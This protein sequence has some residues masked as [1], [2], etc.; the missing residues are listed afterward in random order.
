M[1]G[2]IE[3][4]NAIAFRMALEERLRNIAKN[5]GTDIQRLRKQVAFDRF[6]ARLFSNSDSVSWVLKGGYAMELRIKEARMTKDVDLVVNET[7]TRQ[8][9]MSPQSILTILREQ[10]AKDLKDFFVF[11]IDRSMQDLDGP[12]LY[13]NNI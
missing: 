8:K 9:N 7:L 10:A 1:S 13:S 4:T 11:I 5:E 6:L 3:Y 12:P 2:K